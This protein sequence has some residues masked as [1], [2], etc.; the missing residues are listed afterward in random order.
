MLKIS[1]WEN[2]VTLMLNLLGMRGINSKYGDIEPEYRS[3]CK[4][5]MKEKWH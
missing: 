3:L 2:K 1:L 5:V 4:I